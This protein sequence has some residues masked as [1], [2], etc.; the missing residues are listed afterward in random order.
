MDTRRKVD[1]DMSHFLVYELEP[2]THVPPH[3]RTDSARARERERLPAVEAWCTV[4]WSACRESTLHF[5]T[6]LYWVH[7]QRGPIIE[8]ATVEVGMLDFGG[9]LGAPLPLGDLG[10]ALDVLVH[11]REHLGVPELDKLGVG[12]HRPVRVGR[13]VGAPHLGP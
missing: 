11:E 9:A 13:R 8:L 2:V 10:L 12:R 4:S 7:A 1:G 6:R 3:A 5:S